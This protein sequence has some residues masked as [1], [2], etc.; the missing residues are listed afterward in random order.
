MTR[1]VSWLSVTV[2]VALAVVGAEGHVGAGQVHP[3]TAEWA[4]FL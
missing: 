2:A 4:R 3:Q 1:I